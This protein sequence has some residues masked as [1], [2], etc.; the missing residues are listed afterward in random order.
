MGH[1]V[2]FSEYCL[3]LWGLIVREGSVFR[4]PEDPENPKILE[5]PEIKPNIFDTIKAINQ[6]KGGGGRGVTF[7]SPNSQK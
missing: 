2:I 3:F 7:K 5:V 6:I 4:N 1:R